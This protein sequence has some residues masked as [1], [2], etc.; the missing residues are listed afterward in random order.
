MYAPLRTRTTTHRTVSKKKNQRALTLDIVAG[1]KE[2][3]RAMK[4][5]HEDGDDGEGK[6][7]NPL[8]PLNKERE[9]PRV[10]AHLM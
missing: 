5:D 3:D 10:R 1:K 4:V 6:G 8:G 2:I 7:W 9:N